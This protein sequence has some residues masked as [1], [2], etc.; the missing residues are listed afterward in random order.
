MCAGNA[1]A[2]DGDELFVLVAAS[3]SCVRGALDEVVPA[4]FVKRFIFFSYYYY[5]CISQNRRQTL[6]YY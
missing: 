3:I 4:V 6:L 1:V 5:S 2:E